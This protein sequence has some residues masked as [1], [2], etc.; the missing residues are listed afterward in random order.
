M[1]PFQIKP[2]LLAVVAGLATDAFFVAFRV[3]YLLRRLLGEGSLTA[4]FIPV[5]TEARERGRPAEILDLVLC[6]DVYHCL[7]D[8]LDRQDYGRILKHLACLDAEEIVRKRRHG[9][10]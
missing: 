2:S 1:L 10:V 7:P 3:P 4:S 9:T 5:F 8:E 6:R